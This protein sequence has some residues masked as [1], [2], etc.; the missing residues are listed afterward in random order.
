MIIGFLRS[1]CGMGY[2]MGHLFASYVRIARG[3]WRVSKLNQPVVTIFGGSK[4]EQSH[5]Y[6]KQ[7][8]QLAELLVNHGVSVITGGGPG[9]MEAANCGAA[10]NTTQARTIGITV[11]RL[12]REQLN[13]C[14][15]ETII[16]KHFFARK[17]LLTRYSKGFAVFPGGFGTLDELFEIITLMQVEMMMPLPVVLIGTKYW[18]PLFDWMDTAVQEGLILKKDLDLMLVT[19]DIQEAFNYLQEKRM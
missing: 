15:N 16:V 4:L 13:S 1:C 18:K 2:L 5:S 11:R 7:A 9:I 8:H 10:E 6:A 14:M 12:A 19:D 3:A 17:W